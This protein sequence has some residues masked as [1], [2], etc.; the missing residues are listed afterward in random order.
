M[1][2]G[3]LLP[4][5]PIGGLG[6][7]PRISSS[8]EERAVNECVIIK[9]SRWRPPQKLFERE[10]SGRGAGALPA[11]PQ[12][13]PSINNLGGAGSGGNRSPGVRS[14][15]SH[16]TRRAAPT[17]DVSSSPIVLTRQGRSLW[18]SAER[19]ARASC[20]RSSALP[21]RLVETQRSRLRPARDTRWRQTAICVRWPPWSRRVLSSC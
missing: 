10:K 12:S 17:A 6:R 14:Y 20:T 3:G 9:G 7:W 18:R 2:H 11:G 15:S 1:R 4:A 8:T 16:C 21:L 5:E 13:S 19:R